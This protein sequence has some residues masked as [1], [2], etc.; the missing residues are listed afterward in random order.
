MMIR[1]TPGPIGALV[2][3]TALCQMREGSIPRLPQQAYHPDRS[4]RPCR[5][6]RMCIRAITRCGPQ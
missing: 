2:G 1:E 6:H 3:A 5:S 4:S